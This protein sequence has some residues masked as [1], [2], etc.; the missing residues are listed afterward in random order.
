MTGLRPVESCGWLPSLGKPG[1]NVP[2]QD[3]I[4]HYSRI[5]LL[6]HEALEV[7]PRESR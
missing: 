3:L 6:F 5:N 2:R 4:G 1:K 7:C